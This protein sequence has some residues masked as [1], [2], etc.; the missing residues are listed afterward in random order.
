MNYYQNW[1]PPPQQQGWQP[2]Y[3]VFIPMPDPKTGRAPNSKSL[4]KQ[5]REYSEFMEMMKG[6]KKDEPKKDDGKGELKMSPITLLM[7]IWALSIPVAAANIM[8][9]MTVGRYIMSIVK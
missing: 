9:A 7:W 1:Q 2:P 3:P 5:F 8:V 6:G 4:K